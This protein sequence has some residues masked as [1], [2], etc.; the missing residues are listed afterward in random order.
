MPGLEKTVECDCGWSCRGTEEEV[1]AACIAH[2][3]EAHGMDISREQVLSVAKPA[4][5]APGSHTGPA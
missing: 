5:A 3:R 1:V 4:D 2:G